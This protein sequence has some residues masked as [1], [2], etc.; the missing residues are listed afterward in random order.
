MNLKFACARLLL[1]ILLSPC[2]AITARAQVNLVINGGFDVRE[3]LSFSIVPWVQTGTLLLTAGGCQTADGPNAAGIVAGLL[4][5]D[6]PT[7]SGQRYLLSFY[8][9]GYAPDG[10]LPFIHNL[11][12]DWGSQRVGVTSFDSTGRTFSNM[13][14]SRREFEIQ[15]SGG[16]TRLSF[17]NP[18]AISN[19]NIPL[20]DRVQLV[21]IP[22]PASWALIG[23]ASAALFVTRRVRSR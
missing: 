7:V 6:I 21:A 23:L 16:L 11:A 1:L 14:W 4:Y 2:A 17:S 3:G 15:G 12:V 13:G 9:A 18:N 10:P 19:P 22:E 8:V 5:Q 20:L